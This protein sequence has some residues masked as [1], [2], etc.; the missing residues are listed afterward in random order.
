MQ[1]YLSNAYH[2]F[3]TITHH[4]HLV[5]YHCFRAG[6]PL[7][8]LVHDLSKYSPTEFLVGAKYYQGTFSPNVVERKNKGVSYAWIHHKGKN[9]HHFEYWFDNSPNGYTMVPVKMPTKYLI[10]MIC[11]RLAACKTYLGENYKDSSALEYANRHNYSQLMH[12][13]TEASLKEI[14]TLFAEQGETAGFRYLRK[15][16]RQD[17]KHSFTKNATGR[18]KN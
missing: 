16:R 10:E 7:Q 9:K 2:H 4:R 18:A 14:L 15:L 13:E 6:I 11:D 17:L 3:R 8:G 12:P 1:P 5:M